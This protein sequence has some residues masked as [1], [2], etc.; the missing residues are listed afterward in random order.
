MKTICLFSPGILPIPAV[1][2]GAIETLLELLIEQNEIEKKVRFLVVS[3]HDEEAEERS[4]KYQQTDFIY[5]KRNLIFAG[6]YKALKILARK[7][8]KFRFSHANLYYWLGVRKVLAAKPDAV[9]AEGGNYATFSQ[10]T[11]MIGKENVF[12]HLHQHLRGDAELDDIF[13]EVL[14]VSHFV[15]DE[16]LT[17]SNMD[18]GQV[19][20]L[21][22]AIDNNRFT[23]SLSTQGKTALRLELGLSPTDFVV[24]FCGRVVP[25]KGV[26]ELIL[27][28]EKV[29]DPTVKLLILGSPNFALKDKSDYL[30]EVEA[31]VKKNADRMVFTGYVANEETNR[32]YA[33]ADVVSVPTLIEEAAGLVVLEAMSIGRPLIVTNSGGIPEYVTTEL[34]MILERNDELVNNLANSITTLKENETLRSQM[35]KN[36]KERSLR[37]TK[38]VFYTEFVDCFKDI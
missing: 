5:I 36:A 30:E 4:K 33:I 31:L 2:G 1:K 6:A 10:F 16:W 23:D 37:Y 28:L 21:P 25:E 9:V 17:T 11:Q 15:K 12:L 32:Y 14:T 34:A 19:T 8:F 22:N 20:V 18:S 26:K 13:G 29:A 3:V 24:L 35:A 38:E 27:A 7:L